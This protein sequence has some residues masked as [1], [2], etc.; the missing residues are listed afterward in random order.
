M[1]QTRAHG[2]LQWLHYL[3]VKLL[4]AKRLRAPMKP[5]TSTTSRSGGSSSSV[6]TERECYE[7]L[8]E[9]ESTLGEAVAQFKAA[10][11]KGR[12]KTQAIGKAMRLDSRGFMAREKSGCMVVV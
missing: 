9:M 6:F 11:K 1:L 2:D 3:A 7:C 4:T 10:V 5:R 12:R 8:V